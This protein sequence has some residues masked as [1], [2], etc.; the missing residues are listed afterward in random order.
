M[1]ITNKT[2]NGINP[3]VFLLFFSDAD[4]T[5]LANPDR[6][7]M[8]F[9]RQCAFLCGASITYCFT[10]FSKIKCKR[11]MSFKSTKKHIWVRI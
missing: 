2:R 3:K 1:Y 6:N 4:V 11:N 8:A 10:T 5:F 7:F 9:V